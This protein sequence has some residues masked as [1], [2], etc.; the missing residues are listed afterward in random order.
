MVLLLVMLLSSSAMGLPA[1]VYTMSSLQT[2]VVTLYVQT[3][4]DK[5]ILL[6]QT[7]DQVVVYSA[8]PVS[9]ILW[10]KADKLFQTVPP[11]ADVLLS[12]SDLPPSSSS[13]GNPAGGF[14]L[15][16]GDTYFWGPP[17]NLENGA[18][19]AYAGKIL[20]VNTTS[21]TFT[22]YGCVFL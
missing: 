16:C 13:T 4:N 2:S 9:G 10:S 3:A 15:P 7:N 19:L 1:L 22:A 20:L 21:E 18:W 11:A 5:P 8:S 17:E 12:T 6:A 14:A